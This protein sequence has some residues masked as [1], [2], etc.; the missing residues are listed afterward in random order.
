VTEKWTPVARGSFT[1]KGR[2]ALTP[3]ATN[4]FDLA[5]PPPYRPRPLNPARSKL[6]FFLFG[7]V[8][9]FACSY[10]LNYLFFLLRDHHGFGNLGNLAVSALHGLVFTFG[11]WQ[12]G[13]FAQRFGYLTSLQ[14]GFAGMGVSLFAGWFL[15]GLIA[16]L[17]VMMVWTWSMCLTWPALE[18]LVSDGE[19]DRSL[20]HQVGVYNI[21]WSGMA[22]V[23]YFVGGALFDGLGHL[24]LFWLPVAIY[25]AQWVV[26][27][28]M[29]HTRGD[30]RPGAHAPP[31]GTSPHLP[32]PQ[33]L[34]QAVSPKTFLQ[35]AWL[36]NPFAYMGINTL[37]A[38]I[39]ALA[40]ELKLS[41]TETGVFC[42]LWFFARLVTFIGLWRWTG[43]HY[44]FRWLLVAFVTLVLSLGT[45]LLARQYWPLVLAQL[46]FG[47]AVGLIYYS[48][49]FYSMDVGDTQGEHGGLHEAMIG[50]GICIGPAIGAAGLLLAPAVP[51]A[52]AYAV[53]A[54]LGGG[55]VGLLRLRFRGA[56]QPA[57]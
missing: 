55:L 49:L 3:V 41:A 28:W 1:L 57:R 33:A 34:A 35:M 7:G 40:R 15:P 25:A 5:R 9:T 16:Q 32:E 8:N 50:S 53:L 6:P 14:T 29:K 10:Y 20:P 48:S 4:P 36:A 38:V 23:T 24:S 22:A 46:V 27:T 30:V 12:G 26:V 17:L 19:D 37:L 43:W 31:A 47:V 42:S 51:Q 54:L 52:G 18:A 11:A 39:P 44:R 56:R 45:L 13:K 2:V 21:A